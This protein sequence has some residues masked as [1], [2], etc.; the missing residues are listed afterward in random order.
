MAYVILFSALVVVAY[1]SAFFVIGTAK[2]DNSVVDIGWG[3]GFVVVAFFTLFVYG[4]FN[5]RQIITTTLI[6]FWGTRLSTHIFRRNWGRGED[7]RYLQMREKWGDKVLVRS[8]LQIYMLQ[9]FFMLIISYS[10]MLINSHSGREFGL[11]DIL[12]ILIWASGFAVESIADAQLKAFVKTKKPGEVMTGG[13]WRYSRHPNY[14]GEAVQ[15]WGIFVI[16]LSIDG[17]LWAI[18]SPITITILLRFVSGVPYLERTYRDYPAFKEY[19]K[20]TNAFIPWFPR[21][22]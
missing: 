21:K 15:W 14:F 3:A 6:T 4:E 13:L 22:K 9:G 20:E 5:A 18:I 8:F 2:K 7:F 12:G 11:A 10:V 16:A 17:G 19:L 1:M